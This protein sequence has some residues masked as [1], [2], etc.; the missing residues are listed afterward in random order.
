M[1]FLM[2]ASIPNEPFNS[3]IRDGSASHRMQAIMGE[4][5]PE[6]AYFAEFNGIRTATLI[7]HLNEA[8]EMVKY[9]EP[10]FLQMDA[11]VEYHPVMLPEDL[12]K[13]NLAE[14]GKKWG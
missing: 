9:G 1:R 4:L 5:K 13:G 10:F 8:S 7:V 6:A 3:Y 2:K 12:A 14:I 11:E